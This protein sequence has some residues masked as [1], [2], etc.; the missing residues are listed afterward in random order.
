MPDNIPFRPIADGRVSLTELGFGAASLGNLYTRVSNA[1]AAAT[2]EAALAAGIRYVDTAPHYGSGLSERRIGDAI[3]GRADVILSTKVGRL[4][5][6]DRSVVD[7]RERYGFRSPMPFKHIF[8]Y[9]YDAILRSYEDSLQR[10]GLSH[11]DILYVHDIGRLTHGEDDRVHFT[12]LTK[13]GGLR[14]LEQLRSDGAI[15][16]F[17]IGVN[18]TE[19]CERVMDHADLDVILLAGRYTLLEQGAL[20]SLLPRC[21][22]VGTRVVIGGPYNSGI[23]ATG[24]R[25]GGALHYNYEPAVL[26]VI[27]RVRLLEEA[28]EEYGVP[29][30]AAALQ[31]PLAHPAVAS[32]IPGI[33]HLGQMEATLG[34]YRQ[35]IPNDFWTAL[36]DRRLIAVDAPLPKAGR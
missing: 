16:A 3:R 35:N 25:R 22:A 28:C 12:A 15:S 7:D 29:L 32:I 17:G 34:L 10:A 9:S 27:E 1:E 19:A 13:G 11:I 2:I 26:E 5:V 6:P 33:G 18:E 14:A 23:L 8:D 20:G 4:L 30:A 36:R 31:F 24:V 21:L